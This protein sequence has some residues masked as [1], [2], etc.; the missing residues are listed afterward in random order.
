[1]RCCL[2]S[3]SFPRSSLTVAHGYALPVSFEQH[4]LD[5]YLSRNPL[6]WYKH[7]DSDQAGLGGPGDPPLAGGPGDARV[8]GLQ[9]ALGV[10]RTCEYSGHVIMFQSVG[11]FFFI[12]ACLQHTVF[13]VRSCCM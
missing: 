9:S 3:P 12:S 1:M 6:G 10:G 8:A 7:T 13:I 11:I 2:Y 4:R 5:F